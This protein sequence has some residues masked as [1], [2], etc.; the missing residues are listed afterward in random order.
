[1]TI[2]T[3]LI[4]SRLIN[5]VITTKLHDRGEFMYEIQEI[6]T[7]DKLEDVTINLYFLNQSA[8]KTFSH[9]MGVPPVKYGNVMLFRNGFRVWPY[10]DQETTVGNSIKELNK[11]TI[12]S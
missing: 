1:M 6:N 7:F 9:R 10:G 8:K 3:T 11:V 12:V 2:K 4:E 5:G